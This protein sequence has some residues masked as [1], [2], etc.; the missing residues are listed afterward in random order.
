MKKCLKINFTFKR[1]PDVRRS[2]SFQFPEK[3]QKLKNAGTNLPQSVEEE[4][5]EFDGNPVQSIILILKTSEKKKKKKKRKK[6]QNKTNT[7]VKLFYNKK[8]TNKKKK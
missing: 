1:S 5:K 6:S 4:E 2:I 3:L 7:N 8:T